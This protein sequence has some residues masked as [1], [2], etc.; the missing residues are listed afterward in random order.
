MTLTANMSLSLDTISVVVQSLG[1]K[2]SFTTDLTLTSTL[3]DLAKR[4]SYACHRKSSWPNKHMAF[5]SDDGNMVSS[6]GRVQDYRRLAVQED[7]FKRWAAVN[8]PYGDMPKAF[9]NASVWPASAVKT[10]AIERINSWMSDSPICHGYEWD[11]FC[12]LVLRGLRGEVH[13]DREM[14][15]NPNCISLPILEGFLQWRIDISYVPTIDVT[16]FLAAFREWTA[17]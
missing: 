2:I 6:R 4:I 1:G 10:N 5:F 15:Y 12:L 7:H 13:Q 16:E 17:V 8:E 11:D 3:N 9:F 14:G